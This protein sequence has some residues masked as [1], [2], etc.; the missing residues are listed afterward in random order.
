MGNH[1]CGSVAIAF[2]MESFRFVMVVSVILHGGD[3]RA[4][5]FP[6]RES[7]LQ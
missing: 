7:K 3:L 4:C 5:G 6:P 2:V 1:K